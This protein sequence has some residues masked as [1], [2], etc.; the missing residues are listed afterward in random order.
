MGRIYR[1]HA[2]GIL[3]LLK[4]MQEGVQK[5]VRCGDIQ[6]VRQPLAEMQEAAI[7]LG[8]SIEA[9][10]GKESS[11]VKAIESYCELV[12]QLYDGLGEQCG[13]DA[14]LVNLGKQLRQIRYN[15][16]KELSNKYE[17]VFLPYKASMWDSLESVWR[18]ADED[19]DC[20]AYVIPIPY[21]DKNPDG[22]FRSEHY[23]GNEFPEDVPVTHYLEYDLES[24]HPDVIF[25]HNPYDD[26]NFVTSVHPYF[27]TKKLK[28]CAEKLVYIPYYISE[29][30]N[31]ESK[32]VIKGK[33]PMTLTNGVLNSDMVFLQ[34]EN[35]KRLF[36]NILT[37]YIPDI[38]C[39]YWENKIWG[40]GSPKR[41]RVHRVMRDDARLPKSWHDVIYK[42]SGL[43]KKVIFYNISIAALLKNPDMLNKIKDVLLF[44]KNSKD[45]ALWWRPHPLYESTLASMRPDMLME[46]RQIVNQYKQEKW[47]IFDDGVDLEWAIGE[48][49]AYYGDKS[50]VVQLYKE[51]GKPVMIQD[52]TV[53]TQ[54]EIK[55]ED[56]P[57]W[58][59]A[60]CV[61]GE[62]VWF[63]HGK[64]N[65]LMRYNLID[66]YTDFM[67][68]ISEENVFQASS[69][70]G[71][72]KWG[73]RIFLI[74]GWAREIAIFS[75]KEQKIDNLPIKNIK[76]YDQKLLFSKV[77]ADGK[78]LYCIPCF[79]EAILKIDMISCSIQ[80]LDINEILVN[81]G[82]GLLETYIND[83]TK[84]NNE[85]VATLAYTNQILIFDMKTDRICI[86]KIGG[87]EHKFT[88]IANIGNILYLF[89]KANKIII[90]TVYNSFM[91]KEK[92]PIACEG[93]KMISIH[94]DFI[95]F[96]SIDS[97]NIQIRDAEGSVVFSN[98]TE[99]KVHYRSLYND[100]LYGI[101][102]S[103]YT[104]GN[105][106]Y[107]YMPDCVMYQIYQGKVIDQF[108]MRLENVGLNKLEEAI[109]CSKNLGSS[110]NELNNLGLWINRLNEINTNV[111]K[112]KQGCGEKILNVVKGALYE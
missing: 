106:Y 86:K 112:L 61:D 17:M 60:F 101:E 11:T 90:T 1:K 23:E 58:P 43:R 110:E 103:N 107:F 69:Y 88:N 57:I 34:S 10:I 96:D 82:D 79:Y 73:D 15:A 36:V 83:V 12:Y 87:M 84:I 70:K 67:C 9:Y 47:G 7:A 14:V 56:I 13:L 22:T 75:I 44:F 6:M 108:S 76:K 26:H 94:S 72:Y 16:E 63:V 49:D 31:P 46:Y 59:S 3:D 30:I 50:S 89:D 25:I 93:T 100:F 8:T 99:L 95:I 18:A 81:Q 21:Y 80:Y 98:E 4:K 28:E 64:M 38:D 105:F 91:E 32:D 52:V 53:R 37:E 29:E 74:P 68:T 78:Y 48:T 39:S 71:I 2:M 20:D 41:D 40:L 54:H 85:L 24:R 19:P 51:A 77:Y 111:S 66:N 27:Y 45:M 97:T 65:V 55:A 62:D 35:T 5:V 92:Y 102:S 33:A 104:G 109:I 42:E